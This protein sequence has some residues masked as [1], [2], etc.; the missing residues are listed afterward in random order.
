METKTQ[1]VDVELLNPD[2]LPQLGERGRMIDVVQQ[3]HQGRAM[4]YSL[5][6]EDAPRFRLSSF[7]QAAALLW[8][9]ITLGGALLSFLNGAAFAAFVTYIMFFG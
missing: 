6:I 7:V 9:V 8:I 2:L 5:P 1:T 3:H 4:A